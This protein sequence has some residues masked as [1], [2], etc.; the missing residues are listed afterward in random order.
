MKTEEDK[1]Q[2]VQPGAK[3]DDSEGAKAL[4]EAQKPDPFHDYG[5]GPAA[6]ADTTKKKGK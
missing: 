6:A 4:A 5:G 1:I 2:P 3:I